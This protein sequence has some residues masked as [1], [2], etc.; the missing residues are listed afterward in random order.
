MKRIICMMVAAV[1]LILSPLSVAAQTLPYDTY[2][3]DYQKNV[4]PTPA[5]YIPDEVIYSTELECGAFSSPKDM[6]VAGDGTIYVADTGNHRIVVLNSDMTVKGVIDS[7]DNKGVEDTFKGPSGVYCSPENV[8]YIADTDN[9][10]VVILDAEGVLVDIIQD[11]QSEVL[12][13]NFDF[14]PLKVSVDY[15][16]RVYVVA[17]NIFQGIMAF[18]QDHQFMGYFGTINVKITLVERFWRLFS[19]PEQ[20]KRQKQFIPTEFTNIDIDEEGFVF[21]TNLD[22]SGGQAIRKLN[23]KGIDVITQNNNGKHNLSGDASFST[24]KDTY[25]GA[26]EIIDVKVRDGGMFSVLDRKRGRIFTYDN[27]GNILYIFGGMGTQEGT[28][29]IPVALEVYENKI[30]VLD[31]SNCTISVFAPTEYGSAINEAVRLRYEGDESKAIGIWEKVLEMDSNN[32]MAYSGIGKAYL[33]AGDN[34][35]AMYYLKMG[36]NQSFYSIAFKRYRNELLR[37]NL[38]WILTAGLIVVIA[39]VGVSKV[40]KSRMRRK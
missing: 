26:S 3:Y 18:D 4:V 32:E 12:E 13:E 5:A 15:A 24:S 31:S 33:S 20:I 9:K 10:R 14:A 39:G 1:M 25:Q 37:D 2:N 17:K 34:E 11:P 28:F 6:F 40:K 8:L 21:A 16:G 27:E 29:K 30:Y 19:T 7:F 35:K 23:P 22:S 38:G 36:V